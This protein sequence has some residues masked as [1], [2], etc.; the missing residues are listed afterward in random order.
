MRVAVVG[1]RCFD[2]YGLVKAELDSMTN[3]EEIVTGGAI[4]ADAL[5]E[6]YA[7]KNNIKTTVFLPDYKTYGRCAPIKRN[8]EI[9]LNCDCVVAF[10]DGNSRGTLNSITTATKNNKPVKII[11]SK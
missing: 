1:S 5:G 8:L 4:G 6:E 2:D 7:I 3:I 10:W 11:S 9:I